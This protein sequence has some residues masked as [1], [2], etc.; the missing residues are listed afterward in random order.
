[1]QLR[2]PKGVR[3][4]HRQKAARNGSRSSRTTKGRSSIGDKSTMKLVLTK[5]AETGRELLTSK[6][7]SG[8]PWRFWREASGPP[9]QNAGA[10]A[11]AFRGGL[12]IKL[13]VTG[14]PGYTRPGA[15]ASNSDE[16]SQ[17]EEEGGGG[18]LHPCP[19]SP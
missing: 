16:E 19:S 2:Q 18:G 13:S 11:P 9:G 3:G 14:T 5:V 1:M 15:Q 10:V 12:T 8:I 7:P 4:R 6:S 17:R